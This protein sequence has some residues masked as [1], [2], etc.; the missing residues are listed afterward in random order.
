MQKGDTALRPPSII[1]FEQFYLG[2]TAITVVLQMLNFAGLVG[3]D[4]SEAL[5]TAGMLIVLAMSYGMTFLFWYLIARR[6]SNITKWV[7]VVITV[8]GVIGT[9]PLL[10]A[11]GQSNLGYS[12]IVSLVFVLQLIAIAYLFRRDA[13]EWLKSRGQHGI[14]D[15]TAFN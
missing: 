8:L 11:Q 10:I 4:R 14:V 1:R 3:P 12:L 2:A 7:L 13:A 5:G 6:A 15:L 9:V